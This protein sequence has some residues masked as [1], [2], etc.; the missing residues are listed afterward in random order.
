[1]IYRFNGFEFDAVNFQASKDNKA[2]SIEPLVFDL[3]IYLLENKDRVVTRDE[4]FERVWKGRSVQDSTLSNHIKILRSAIDDDGKSQLLVKTVRGRGYQ[5]VANVT[6]VPPKRQV[7]EPSQHL[8]NSKPDYLSN[9][10]P[11]SENPL[12]SLVRS[13]PSRNSYLVIFTLIIGLVG[14]SYIFR[15]SINNQSDSAAVFPEQE[16]SIAVLAFR[17]MSANQNQNYFAE[18]ISEEILNLLAKIKNLKVISRTSSFSYKG[19][20]KDITIIGKELNVRYL[21]EGS[22]RKE[23]D[24]LRITVQLIDAN[25]G[26]HIWSEVYNKTMPD[27]FAL[28]DEIAEV[29]SKKLKITLSRG[30][31]P[32]TAQTAPAAYV[33]YLEANSVFSQHT[34]EATA[35]AK[36]L[37][38]QSIVIDDSYAPAWN[39]LSNIYYRETTNLSLLDSQKG[40][41]KQRETAE[42]SIALDP[43]FAPA[44]ASLARIDIHQWKHR[45]A[46]RNINKSLALDAGN[47]NL[48]A[49]AS[50]IKFWAGYLKESTLLINEAIHIDPV[51]YIN[52]F[53]SA[54]G[55]F[56]S[57]Q[58]TKALE[59]IDKYILRQPTSEVARAYRAFILLELNE[60]E[61]ANQASQFEKNGYWKLYSQS[62]TLY[63]LGKQLESDLAI[64]DF[65]RK[66]ADSDP[67]TIADMYAF[68]KD[69]K[70]T[71][72]WLDKAVESRDDY[73]IET[74]QYPSFEFL[75]QEQRWRGI[76]NSM[77]LFDEHWLY[78]EIESE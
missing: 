13:T 30:E 58:Y 5:F 64:K 7:I 59:E 23:G 47:P 22:V 1:M 14:L 40:Y 52:Y 45:S 35:S 9:D 25:D 11:D 24:S 36:T 70:N 20:E 33:L 31:L 15:Q 8:V 41:Q 50:D 75:H 19:K 18:G 12:S 54:I 78:K 67:S 2:L 29:V 6:L 56:V 34:S 42:K 28:Q 73:L 61:D 37:V 43:T 55:L 51:T 60:Y 71:Y 16:K 76:L 49:S 39:L 77:N 68:R 72:K 65:I 53:N 74:I 4:I 57:K 3:A 44:Y 63:A 48:I 32:K 17:D 38:N 69:K 27:I 21:I 46:I 66:Y 10:Q 26:S 62:K